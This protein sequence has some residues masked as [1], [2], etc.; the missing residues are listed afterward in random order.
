MEEARVLTPMCGLRF[1]KKRPSMAALFTRSIG[2]GRSK[3]MK[4]Q[5]ASTDST[6]RRARARRTALIFGVVAIAIYLI[7]IGE[8][9]LDK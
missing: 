3:N 8:V 1:Q 4:E 6:T 9:V 5:L 7:A 2:H